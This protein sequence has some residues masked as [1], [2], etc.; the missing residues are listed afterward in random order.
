M[1]AWVVQA[2]RL[3]AQGAGL[4]IG[5]EGASRV[6]GREDAA[7][8]G[9]V[10]DM[11]RGP[12]GGFVL[13]D[14]HRRHHRRDHRRRRRKALTQGDRND[15]AFIAATVSKAAAGTFAAQLASRSR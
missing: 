2:L 12:G 11:I 3:I 13:D 8:G 14:G 9:E 6:L 10:F 5:F 4:S 15:I 1:A 7:I